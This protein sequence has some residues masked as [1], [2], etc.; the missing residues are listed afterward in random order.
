MNEHYSGPGIYI[1]E[2]P[3]DIPPVVPVETAVPVFIGYTERVEYA[4]VSLLNRP[5]EI[6]SLSDFATI[7]G[8]APAVG[9]FTIEIDADGGIAGGIFDPNQ[10]GISRFRLAYALNH[11]FLNGGGHC[12]VM[13]VGDFSSPGV[14]SEMSAEHLRGLSA[15]AEQQ[16]PTLIVMP[17]LSGIKPIDPDDETLIDWIRGQY[18][19]VL[20]MALTQCAELGD[21]FLIA[22]V[23][24]GD[25]AKEGV[26]EAFRAGIGYDNLDYGAAYHPFIE[27]SLPWRWDLETIHLSQPASRAA[28]GS[29]VQPGRCHNLALAELL[30]RG[31]RGDRQAFLGVYR[32]VRVALD[33]YSVTLPPSAAI[34][35]IY[36]KVDRERGVWKPPANIAVSAVRALP[37]A[38]DD[39]LNEQMNI[40]ASGKSINALRHFTGK[41]VLVWGA[42]TLAGHN[43]EWRYVPVRRYC[44]MVRRSVANALQELVIDVDGKLVEEMIK[45]SVKEFLM[46]QW[47]AGALA[48]AT[49]E[50]AFFVNCAVN[51][52]GER[53]DPL[54]PRVELYIGVAAVRPAEFITMKIHL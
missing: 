25:T 17:D 23:W 28:D 6:E 49:P 48:G 15:L 36:C 51:P 26:V 24:G 1:E 13:S 43:N 29:L 50:Q 35:G 27:T 39:Q 30:V 47:R 11:Y 8:E 16:G 54:A 31:E 53:S 4:G 34:A 19:E 7:F 3:V 45:A 10:K 21:R 44:S 20:R 41:G 40:D 12:Y 42:R 32:N 2:I 14:M 18:H 5:I 38:I 22:D 46:E 52:D 33:Q 37:T 9:G